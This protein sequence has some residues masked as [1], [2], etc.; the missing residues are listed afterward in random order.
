MQFTQ[1]FFAM[2]GDKII[3]GYTPDL[4]ALLGSGLIITGVIFMVLQKAPATQDQQAE[5]TDAVTGDEES[6]MGL[7]TEPRDLE[8]GEDHDRLST[9]AVQMQTLR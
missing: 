8:T 9:Q 7:L 2:L 5:E 6:R 3:F 4:K 1:M